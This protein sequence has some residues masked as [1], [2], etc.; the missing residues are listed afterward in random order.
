MEITVG[1]IIVRRRILLLI[2]LRVVLQREQHVICVRNWDI[3]NA[4]A[5]ELEEVLTS[6]GDEDESDW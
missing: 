6:G 2:I 1:V 3:L 4:H 5:E